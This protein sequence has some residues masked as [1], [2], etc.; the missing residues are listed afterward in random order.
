MR[1]DSRSI[2]VVALFLLMLAA[3]A[4]LANAQ[5]VSVWLTTDNQRTKLQQQA[6]VTFSIGGG[7]SNPVFVDE[8]QAYQ[9]IEGFGASFTDSAAYLLNQ[10]VGY[11]DDRDY[12]VYQNVNFPSGITSVRARVASAGSG[13]TLE[14]RLDGPTGAL[15]GS[16]AIPNTGGWQRWKTVSGSVSGA[17][18]LHNLHLVFRG[19]TSIGNVNWFQFN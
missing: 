12:A 18:G 6:S 7:G 19:S 3:T 15:I 17:T 8:T 9:R 16:V 4:T 2:R 10:D 11:A 13:G 1:A 5:T 14:F